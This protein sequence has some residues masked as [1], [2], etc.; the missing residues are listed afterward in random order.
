MSLLLLM[1]AIVPLLAHGRCMMAITSTPIPAC[2]RG[3]AEMMCA[4]D[5]IDG[6]SS[7]QAA[8]QP[9]SDLT[10]IQVV[11]AQL[12]A[13]QRG[14]VEVCFRFASPNNKRAT[15]PWQRFELMVRQTP[16]YAPLVGCKEFAVVGAI[17]VGTEGYR[18]RVRVWPAAGAT[19]PRLSLDDDGMPI[20]PPVLDYDWQLSQQPDDSI[21][22]TTAGCW[23]VD[24]VMPDAPP[25]EVW[26]TEE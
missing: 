18:C 5:R 19:M 23:M 25:R 1:A 24:A 2:R 12:A 26:T 8:D 6:L 9:L 16:A 17:P 13:L 3:A 11:E 7:G 10:P 14:D 22:Y 15:G 21:D 4:A 20:A